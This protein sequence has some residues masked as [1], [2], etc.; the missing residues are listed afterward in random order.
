LKEK[1]TNNRLNLMIER[2]KSR[3]KS[4]AR[5]RTHETDLREMTVNNSFMKRNNTRMLQTTDDDI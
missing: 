2:I 3:S 5:S 4:A 1:L